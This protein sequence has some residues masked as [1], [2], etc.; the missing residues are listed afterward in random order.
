MSK[1]VR[2][3]RDASSW[4]MRTGAVLLGLSG[5]FFGTFPLLRPTGDE[6]GAAN[7]RLVAQTM[8]SNEW[9]ISHLL[10]GLAFL[11]LIFGA[12]TLYSRLATT[13]SEP[14]AFGAII[15][16]LGG[17]ALLLP[18]IGLEAIA[19][20]AVA[21]MAPDGA[22]AFLVGIQEVR[23]GVG[24]PVFLVGLL[25]L[26]VGG[27]LLAIAIWRTRVLPRWAGIILATGLALFLPLLPPPVRIADGLAILLGAGFLARALWMRAP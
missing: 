25:L 6:Q 11:L 13:Q 9:L 23:G 2:A 10:V 19:L 27:I 3:I 17:I 22:G 7:T 1:A 21:K 12:L 16:L 26:A 18:I 24:A 15:A 4:R 5:F 14:L 8:A 20:R